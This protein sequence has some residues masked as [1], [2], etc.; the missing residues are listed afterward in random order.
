GV[1]GVVHDVGLGHD[2]V[3]LP[4]V[5]AREDLVA[6]GIDA[7]DHGARVH[8][9]AGLC[10]VRRGVGRRDRACHLHAVVHGVGRG[11]D[12][13]ALPRVACGEDRVAGAI[14]AGDNGRGVDRPA[15]PDHVAGGVGGRDGARYLHHV[16]HGVRRGN[17]DI[18]LP[19]VSGGEDRVAGGIGAGG[20]WRRVDRPA[21]LR[22]IERWVGRG[23]GARYLHSDLALHPLQRPDGL[24]DDVSGLVARVDRLARFVIA[25]DDRRPLRGDV[26]LHPAGFVDR[27]VHGVRDRNGN[28]A[29]PP[30]VGGEL[31]GVDRIARLVVAGEHVLHDRRAVLRSR[32]ADD[33]VGWVGRRDRAR[34]GLAVVD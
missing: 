26:F 22:E 10:D 12:D 19:R 14:G 16:V 34:H 27:V 21:G 11:N 3:A 20:H 25:G 6:T 29:L 31:A 32:V 15:G 30:V 28:G 24:V 18:A 8:G 17:D 33:M 1:D 4:L 13:I 9:A 23:Y 7:G 5:A 2:D